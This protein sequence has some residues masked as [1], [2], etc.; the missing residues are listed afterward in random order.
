MALVATLL[1]ALPSLAQD[2][3]RHKLTAD[4]VVVRHPGVPA[5]QEIFD[6]LSERCRLSLRVIPVDAATVGSLDD[7]IGSARVLVTLGQDALD[8]TSKRTEQKIAVLAAYG[9][10]EGVIAAPTTGTPAEVLRALKIALPGVRSIGVVVGPRQEAW[11]QRVVETAKRSGVHVV[12]ARAPDGPAA[13][14]ALLRISSHVGVLLVWHY[15]ALRIFKVEI[16]PV[17]A[18]L[19]LP[20]YFAIGSLPINVNGFG[21]A[22]VVA[23]AFFSPYVTQGDPKTA[24][25]AYSLA[26]TTVALVLQLLLGLLCLRR[27]TKLGV[28][29]DENELPEATDTPVL[30]VASSVE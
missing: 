29:T 15:I 18:L 25:M 11:L 1:V 13:L 23:I 24:V 16:P 28:P 30:R 8:A 4:V 22:Q 12:Q 17:D 10:G 21:V 27:A 19:Y 2:R 6:E 14:R 7:R 3:V 26:T 20:A 9:G 5:Y